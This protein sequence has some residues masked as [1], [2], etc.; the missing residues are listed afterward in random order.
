MQ[1]APDNQV[2]EAVAEHL[3]GVIK[4]PAWTRFVKTGNHKERP[5]ENP[6]W[7]YIRAA[8]VLKSVNKLGPVGV[9]KLRVKYGGKKNRGVK[10]E[11]FV[12]GS[13]NLLR[14][15]LQQLEQAKLIK[16]DQKDTYKGRVI[17]PAGK[18][19]LVKTAKKLSSHKTEVKKEK[20]VQAKT[21]KTHEKQHK[22]EEKK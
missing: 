1:E 7:W 13:G 6:D 17:T 11:K 5:P 18:S 2:I 19:L 22:K 10:P 4:P 14:K 21:E 16:Q 9:S 3:K 12:K 15:V 20:P 8:A